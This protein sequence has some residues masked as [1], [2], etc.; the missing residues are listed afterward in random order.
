MLAIP[1]SQPNT[2]ER[3]KSMNAPIFNNV[4][5]DKLESADGLEAVTSWVELPA[6]T[7]LPKH[8]HP[9]EEFAYIVEG[10]IYL[11]EE[12]VGETL[13][14]AGQSGKVPMNTVHTVRTTDE[15][16]KLVVF[17]I[18]PIGE[19]ERTLVEA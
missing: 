15:G 1:T 3:D 19:P 8:T 10:S 12:G 4:A 9:G 2:K 13:Y 11:W 14:S 6:D 5:T 18:H 17:R 16:A 7:Q